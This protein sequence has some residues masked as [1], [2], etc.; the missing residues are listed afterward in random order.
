MRIIKILF[1]AE[2]IKINKGKKLVKI[3]NENICWA[4]GCHAFRWSFC[5]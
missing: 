5:T 1:T 2:P 4:D 3:I